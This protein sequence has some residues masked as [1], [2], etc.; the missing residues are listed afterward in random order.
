[1]TELLSAVSAAEAFGNTTRALCLSKSGWREGTAPCILTRLREE[2]GGVADLD[3]AALL[4]VVALLVIAR[5]AARSLPSDS[6]FNDIANIGRSYW[7]TVRDA[8]DKLPKGADSRHVGDM[9]RIARV[10]GE[11]AWNVNMRR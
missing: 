4:R 1:M 11:M 8:L 7:Q 6:H 3:S 5:E 9:R 10:I 2:E